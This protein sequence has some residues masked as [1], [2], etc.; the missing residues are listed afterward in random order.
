MPCFPYRC[1]LNAYRAPQAPACRRC[2]P[3]P[4]VGKMTWLLDFGGYSL[5]NA[6]SI[7]TSINVLQVLQN[8][9]PERLGLAVC[10]HAPALFSVTW[11][12]R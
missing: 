11:K 3:T 6:P 9:Y 4:G 7:R 8:H 12:V 5:R 1:G 2:F 10:Y